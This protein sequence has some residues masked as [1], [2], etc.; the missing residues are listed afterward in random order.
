MSLYIEVGWSEID[1]DGTVTKKPLAD[2][3]FTATRLN[4]HGG[5]LSMQ[6]HIQ[7]L[8]ICGRVLE[9]ARRRHFRTL[10]QELTGEDPH[11]KS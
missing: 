3:A 2:A 1:D 5:E 7:L 11:P 9:V 10:E 8:E 4:L 6:Y